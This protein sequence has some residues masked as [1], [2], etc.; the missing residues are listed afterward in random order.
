M[1]DEIGWVDLQGVVAKF[2]RGIA[3]MN[4]PDGGSTSNYTI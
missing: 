3:G 2:G 1:M 4:F